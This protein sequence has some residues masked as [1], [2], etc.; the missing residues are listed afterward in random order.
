MYLHFCNVLVNFGSPISLAVG[1]LTCTV[2]DTEENIPKVAA[3]LV[4]KSVG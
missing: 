1:V 3:K 2:L 4:V